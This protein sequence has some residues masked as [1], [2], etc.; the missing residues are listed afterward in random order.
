MPRLWW[1]RVAGFLGYG[2]AVLVVIGHG[3]PCRPRV[4]PL[5]FWPISPQSP[6]SSLIANV[7]RFDMNSCTW[8]RCPG[9]ASERY[10]IAQ[11]STHALDKRSLAQRWVG[12]S[13]R[14]SGLVTTVTDSPR[15]AGH[16]FSIGWHKRCPRSN[17]DHLVD[18]EL[19]AFGVPKSDGVE[20][21]AGF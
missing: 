11:R 5:F 16:Q 4:R 2:T 6:W 9:G 8:R 18:V 14:L 3:A 15:H 1:S 20:M 17:H 13:A 19:V 12:L 7:Y 10:F 21:A